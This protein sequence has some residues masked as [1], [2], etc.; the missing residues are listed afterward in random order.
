MNPHE[1]NS[2][3]NLHQHP[4]H[5]GRQ[6]AQ[7]GDLLRTA[8]DLAREHLKAGMNQVFEQADDTLFDSAEKAGNNQE[9]TI[10]FDSMR[11]LRKQRAPAEARFKQAIQETFS[12]FSKGTLESLHQNDSQMPEELS[13]VDDVEL[14]ED[15]AI[16]NMVSKAEN[17][18]ARTLYA[19][20]Q[21]LTV[22]SGGRKVEDDNNP[23]GP[24]WVAKAC[25]DAFD[26]I[27]VDIRIKLILYKLFDKHVMSRLSELYEQLNQRFIEAGVLPQIQH[28]VA[29]RNPAAGAGG[30][31]NPP[32][33]EPLEPL[34]PEDGGMVDPATGQPLDP[35]TGLPM[36]APPA[37]GNIPAASMAG[38]VPAAAPAASG[39]GVGSALG[40]LVNNIS[41]LLRLRRGQPAAGNTAP[42][43]APAQGVPASNAGAGNTVPA[44]YY[45]SNLVVNALSLLQQQFMPQLATPQAMIQQQAPLIPKEQLVQQLQQLDSSEEDQHIASNDEDAIDLV[46][47]LFEFIVQDRNL[48]SEIQALLSRLQIP[49]LKAAL[50]DRHLFTSKQHPA[51]LLLDE[52]AQVGLGW[53][54]ETDKDGKVIGKLTSIVETLLT[55]FDEDLQLFTD[56]HEDLRAFIDKTTHRAELAEQ[57]TQE[58]VKGQEKLEQARR[59]AATALK[60]ILDQAP[61]DQPEMIS[62]LVSKAWANVLVLLYLR[63]GEDSPAWKNA[64]KVAHDLL[65]IRSVSDNPSE[66]SLQ[67]LKKVRPV[68]NQALQK[69]LKLIAYRQQDIDQLVESLNRYIEHT[70]NPRQIQDILKKLKAMPGESEH[71]SLQE[72]FVDEVLAEVEAEQQLPPEELRQSEPELEEIRDELEQLET[73]VWFEFQQDDGSTLRA[74]LSWISPISG[75]YL[76][77]NQK[78]LKVA[79]KSL[80]TLAEEIHEGRARAL[81]QSPLLDRAMGSIV[82]QLHEE[83]GELEEEALEIVEGEAAEPVEALADESPMDDEWTGEVGQGDE[84]D[85]VRLDLSEDELFEMIDTA[86]DEDDHEN[87]DQR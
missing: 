34:L 3:V 79:D 51:R 72:D 55:D 47:M 7:L 49:Y 69:G 23:V 11:L 37:A 59:A 58:K 46:A 25:R 62:N 6:Q 80:T 48:P 18:N 5:P 29:G 86:A 68:L 22:I 70:S 8:M 75:K 27:E 50:L 26:L 19:L 30:S 67:R 24:E 38:G 52:M 16:S 73:G 66:E 64:L 61:A 21:R 63:Q 39:G 32:G 42:G 45:D 87:R 44:G 9:Q 84:A 82:E 57:R 40:Q 81:D 41:N 76:F 2:I 20:N 71:A 15:L 28:N 85:D 36:G 4:K 54:K 10:Y 43:A 13:L 17:R 35:A 53:N 77:V 83:V 60:T 65:W 56:L 1:K 78:G 12:R 31:Y 14:E 33:S 74:K